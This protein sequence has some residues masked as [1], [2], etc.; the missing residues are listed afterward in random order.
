MI[1]FILGSISAVSVMISAVRW[2][3][4]AQREHYEPGRVSAI[5]AIWWRNAPHAIPHAAVVV[6]AAT[7][8]LVL[9]IADQ[10][11]GATT[12]LAISGTA[13]AVWPL[14]LRWRGKERPLAFTAR[15]RRLAAAV[16]AIAATSAVIVALLANNALWAG[17]FLAGTIIVAVPTVVDLAAAVM[18]PVESALARTFVLAARQKLARVQP[19]IVAITGSFGK[20]STKFYVEHIVGAARTTL[21]SPASFNNLLG[22]S[23]AVN[24][25]LTPDIEVFIA[26]MGT[27]GLGEI[28]ELCEQFPP[29]IAAITAIG[30][31][32]LER[33]GSRENIAAA[34]AEILSPASTV[35]VNADARE[36]VRHIDAA[37]AEG[38][39]I[40]EFS[41]DP[42][43]TT[44][45]PIVVW[46]HAGQ[47]RVVVDEA[48]VATTPALAHAHPS[49]VACAVAIAISLDIPISVITRQLSSLPTVP[50]RANSTTAPAGYTVIDDTYNSNPQG[51][52]AALNIAK[53]H[54]RD[55][56]GRVWVVTPGMI[57]LG[58]QQSESNAVLA[59]DVVA[60]GFLVIVGYVNRR[61]LM[62]GATGGNRPRTSGRGSEPGH[63]S[64]PER[65]YLTARRDSA[66]ALVSSL[67]QPG[68][69]VLYE[70]DLPDHYP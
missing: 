53:K 49:N 8:A 19:C 61:A 60:A 26:E 50:H 44:E 40:I 11:T 42:E 35:V 68:D 2:L 34:K 28:T 52:E 63:A 4:V 43:R 55:R 21:A 13:S 65:I 10:R 41:S 64:A 51:A 39:R 46:S 30:D 20:T 59:A 24:D 12:L 15:L 23:K 62:S 56:G 1:P 3:R 32:H 69:A 9:A 25:R 22:L 57:E 47:L 5:A 45:V 33:M 54:A 18:R 27:Y 66:V 67:A 36:L 6:V 58:R 17:V 70:N 14:G 38:K 31:V 37:R 29:T 48:L 16:A 7:L